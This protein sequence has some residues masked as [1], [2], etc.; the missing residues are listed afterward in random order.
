MI[1]ICI[2]ATS[3]IA[4]PFEGSDAYKSHME[5]LGYEVTEKDK[6]LQAKHG[7]Y[8]NVWVKAYQKGILLIGYFGR[9]KEH[10]DDEAGFHKMIND[11]NKG[12]T[13]ARYYEDKDGDLA[14]EAWYPGSYEKVR[15][16]IFLD[17]FHRTKTQ[18]SNENRLETHV[19]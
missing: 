7:K 10:K 11:L 19:I 5:F 4:G 2:G 17:S 3:A 15:F 8:L 9:N 13:A 6:A 12:A 14:I 18:L 1:V 16:G